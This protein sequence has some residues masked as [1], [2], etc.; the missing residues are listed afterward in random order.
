M[1]SRITFPIGVATPGTVSVEG[2]W[3]CNA[4]GAL[5]NVMG[6]GFTVA[7]TGVG[8]HTVTFDKAYLGYIRFGAHLA[9]NAVDNHKAQVGAYDPVARTLIINTVDMAAGVVADEAS[10]A[11][12]RV[13]LECVFKNVS[14]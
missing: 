6:N 3:Q 8:E 14:Y 11:N 13:N 4:A 10:H 5:S 1:S 9:L 7:R 12:N 2:S